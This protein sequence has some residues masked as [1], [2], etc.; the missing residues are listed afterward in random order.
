MIAHRTPTTAHGSW[1][2]QTR[3][4]GLIAC[5]GAFRAPRLPQRLLEGRVLQ[6][7]PEQGPPVQGRVLQGRVLQGRVLQGRV[8]QGRVLQGR[9]CVVA[10]GAGWVC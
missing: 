9:L 4:L 5:A 2:R 6:E 8:L 10:T 3:S 1:P 7:P